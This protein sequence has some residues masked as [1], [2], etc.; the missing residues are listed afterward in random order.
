MSRRRGR[1]GQ[2]T[3]Y[4]RR[5]GKYQGQLDCGYVGGRRK[6]LT[7]TGTSEGAV[8]AKLQAAAHALR[9]GASVPA[10]RQTFAQFVEKW[11]V[12][13]HGTVRERTFARYRGLLV[14]AV[15]VLGRARLV[16]L[17]PADLVRLYD[18]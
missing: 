7:F 8:I 16:E 3:V 6:R 15:A 11:L 9:R 1:R 10:E 2:G 4:R 12:A 14:Q 5:D 17:Q 13:V 18:D